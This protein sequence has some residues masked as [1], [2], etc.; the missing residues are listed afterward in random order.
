MK[1]S[2]P[3]DK[4][5]LKVDLG[6]GPWKKEG[7]VG[8][9]NFE[10]AEQWDTDPLKKIDIKHD[11]SKGIPFDDSAVDEFFAAHFLEHT[12]PDFMLREIHRAG[13]PGALVEL[14]IPYAN[15]AEGMY[16]GHRVFF[17]EKFF[18]NNTLFNKLFE[19][20]EFEYTPT[21]EWERF[22]LQGYSFM[23]FHVARKF[24][25]NVCKQFTVRCRVKK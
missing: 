23:P 5:P 20:V 16:P 15:S 22:E 3:K 21:E 25:F 8:I 18:L 12:D 24:M 17:T 6:C 2:K 1:A 10:G 14:I 11:L 13:R 4:G 7:F 9:D 19:E